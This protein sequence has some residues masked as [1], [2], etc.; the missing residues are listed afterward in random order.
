MNRLVLVCIVA[1]FIC[2]ASPRN[3]RLI[4]FS[5]KSKRLTPRHELSYSAVFIVKNY[6]ASKKCEGYIDSLVLKHYQTKNYKQ[7]LVE[8]YN[9]SDKINIQNLTKNPEDFDDYADQVRVSTYRFLNGKFLSKDKY[10]NGESIETIDTAVI[11][12]GA[13][14][15][16]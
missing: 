2:C 8:L 9:E 13:A 4:F 1:S 7:Y 12:V 3:Q 5:E 6:C 15:P 11:K 16:L 14:Q 10:K